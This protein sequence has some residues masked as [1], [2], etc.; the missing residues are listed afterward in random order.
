MYRALASHEPALQASRGKP[1][2]IPLRSFND[3]LIWGT[4]AL[5]HASS[6]SHIDDEGF[7]TVSSTQVGFKYWV[8]ARPSRDAP[9][10]EKGV[11]HLGSIDA[12]HDHWVPS[13]ACT[14]KF[15]YE[16]VL[17]GPGTILW[18]FY[19]VQYDSPLNSKLQLYET[20]H[21]ALCHHP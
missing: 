3:D 13:K 10:E 8:V 11:G 6:W 19:C 2:F 9:P 18:V 4:A 17:L 5:R 7:G 1:G 16:G 12:F 14:K 21:S 15:D 20:M